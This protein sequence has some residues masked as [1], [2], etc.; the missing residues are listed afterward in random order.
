MTTP[1]RTLGSASCPAAR[2]TAGV[3][4]ANAATAGTAAAFMNSRRRRYRFSSVISEERMSRARLMIM[5]SLIKHNPGD[6]PAIPFAGIWQSAGAGGRLQDGPRRF[7][8]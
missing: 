2:A 1:F 8:P 6:V 4:P 7:R 5:G 3:S